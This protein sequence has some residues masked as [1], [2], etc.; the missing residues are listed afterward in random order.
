[1]IPDTRVEEL[2]DRV[3]ELDDRV[4]ELHERVE[5]RNLS[6]ASEFGC[7]FG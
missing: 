2:D 5:E 4:E 7:E 1:L 3:E 6:R